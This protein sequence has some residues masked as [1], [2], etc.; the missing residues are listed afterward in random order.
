MGSLSLLQGIF[1][2]KGL[3]PGLLHCR[4]TLYQLS[5]QGSPRILEWV[6]YPFS[7]IS[8][9][10]RNQIQ[11]SHI[12]G[13]FF[14]TELSGKPLP[15]Q[16]ALINTISARSPSSGWIKGQAMP[17]RQGGAPTTVM[18][19]R[20]GHT[21]GEPQG[22]GVIK[23]ASYISVG[24]QDIWS[25]IRKHIQGNWKVGSRLLGFLKPM[26]DFNVHQN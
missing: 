22:S 24:A 3:N 16:R 11:V 18:A 15:G 13:R 5:N 1:L 10:P 26:G 14:T 20:L 12:A 21:K 6:P 23:C 9:R 19:A 7:S 25:P 8:S 2:T 4:W 17:G